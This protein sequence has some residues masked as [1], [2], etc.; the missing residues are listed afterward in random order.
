[1]M[2]LHMVWGI[3]LWVYAIL[4]EGIETLSLD[5]L[6]ELYMDGERYCYS[7]QNLRSI[8][9]AVLLKIFWFPTFRRQ[10]QV[11]VIVRPMRPA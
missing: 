4:N 6:K 7:L 1:M 3:M 5:Y 8:K 11:D 9:K 10:R 2:E